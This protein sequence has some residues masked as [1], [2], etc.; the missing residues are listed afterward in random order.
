MSNI[1]IHHK[2]IDSIH[3]LTTLWFLLNTKLHVY[4]IKFDF[5]PHPKLRL[6]D[7]IHNFKWVKTIPIWQNGG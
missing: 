1:V 5:S 7:A 2:C 3:D 6:A 4:Y